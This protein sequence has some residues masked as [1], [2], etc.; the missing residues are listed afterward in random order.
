M[1]MRILNYYPNPT[2]EFVKVEF[3][4]PEDEPVTFNLFDS[5]GKFIS[6]EEFIPR[7][8][9]NTFEIDLSAQQL[10][11]YLITVSNTKN[12]ASCRVVKRM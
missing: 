11:I 9:K 7:K 1:P 12:R 4:S 3:Y 8:G 5:M 10:G 2:V 6:S